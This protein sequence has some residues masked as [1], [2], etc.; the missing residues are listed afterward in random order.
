[1]V[2][3]KNVYIEVDKL[4]EKIVDKVVELKTVEERIIN[5]ETVRENI[6]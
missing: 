2:V 1:M 5:T 4:V 6:V 3:E